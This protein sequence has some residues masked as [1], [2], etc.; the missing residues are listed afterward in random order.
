MRWWL[1]RLRRRFRKRVYETPLHRHDYEMTFPNGGLGWV[2]KCRCGDS[3]TDMGEAIR[4][5]S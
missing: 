5:M 3:T 1:V 2:L 4:R